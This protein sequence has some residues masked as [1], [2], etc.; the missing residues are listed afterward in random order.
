MSYLLALDQGTTSSRAL[1]FDRS[2]AVR[3]S[4]Q[5]EF[6]QHFPAP[7]WVE[8]DP[9]DLWRTQLAT[10]RRALGAAGIGAREVAAI[11]ITNQRET[12]LAWNRATG[13]PLCRALVWQDRRTASLTDRLKTEGHE[14]GVRAK[15]GLVLDP[16]FSGSKVA[17]L[18]AHV[19]G[20]RARAEGGR[21]CFGTV[22]SWLLWRLTGGAVHAT[23][24]TNASRTLLFDLHTLAWDEALLDLFGVPAG[25]LPEVRPSAGLFGAT[26]PTLFGRPIPITG[27]AGDQ[28]AALFGQACLAPGMAKNTYGTGAFAVMHVGA[29]P[30]LGDGV[31]ATVAWQLGGQPAEYALEGSIF[32]AGAAVQWLRDGLGLIGNAAEVEALATSVP[33]AGGVTFVP[34][35]TGLGAP[36]WDPHARGVIGGLTRGTTRAHLARAALEAIAFQTRDAL[37]AMAAA[38]GIPVREL[39]V[40]GGAAGNDLLLQLQADLLDAPVV[41]PRI[42]ETTALGAAWLAGVGAGLFTPKELPG[43]WAEERRF[44]PSLA[45]ADRNARC[46]GWARAVARARGWA[47]EEPR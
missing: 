3:G 4:A 42:T 23:D 31:L 16:Y 34:A 46:R 47:G 11:G 44:L 12:V 33:D 18:L 35:L 2:G 22:D 10:A 24:V 7:G 39:R 20:L 25:A 45:A 27:V 6:P 41:R 37:A 32:V 5:E 8:H 1:V 21:A 36:Y 30:V 38:S 15:T 14:P 13:A 17:W 26:D 40:D 29:R 28:Q 9:E 43:Q 19:P